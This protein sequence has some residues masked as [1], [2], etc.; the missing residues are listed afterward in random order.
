MTSGWSRRTVLGLI[1]TAPTLALPGIARAK[2]GR[3]VVVGGG[4]GGSAAARRI[5][6]L[7]P[8]ID[9][10]LIARDTSFVCCPGSNTVIGGF[11]RIEDQTVGYDALAKDGVTIIAG[12]AEAVD[13][14]AR[15]LRLADG[16]VL[17]YDKLVLSPGIGF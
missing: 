8:G 10:T 14:D 12:R 13:T 16:S 2:G 6:Q 9:V 1:A 5:K 17:P 3:V 15:T 7:A 11:G 4:F